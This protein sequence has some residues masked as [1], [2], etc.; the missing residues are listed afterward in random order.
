M[1]KRF[2]GR[3]MIGKDK[4]FIAI[5]IST[6][7]L[8]FSFVFWL[9]F[10]GYFQCRDTCESLSLT[11]D[12]WHPV[13]IAR[14]VQALYTLFDS[15]S[16]YLF[17]MNI[18]C[19]YAG[20]L[21]FVLPLY[22]KTRNPISYA[23]FF[24][25]VIGNIFFQNFVQHNSFG[26]PMLMW[27]GCSMLF[28][29]LLVPIAN[30]RLRIAVKICTGIVLLF[31]FLWR[32]NA[33]ISVYPLF[34]LFIYLHLKRKS[35][36]RTWAYIARFVTF[37]VAVAMIMVLILKGYPHVLSRNI[38]EAPANH[39]SLHQIAG[40]VTPANDESFIPSEWYEE[41]KGF[42]DLVTMYEKYPTAADPFNGGWD[43]T[44]ESRFF[45]RGEIEGSKALWL[46]GIVTYPANYFGH[47][48]QFIRTMWFQYPY[49]IFDSD[50]IQRAP[51][52]QKQKDLAQSYPEYERHITFSPMQ[53]SIYD[54]LFARRIVL[55]H[56]VGIILGFA[57]LAMSGVIWLSLPLRRDEML[58]FTFSTSLSACMTAIVVYLFSCSHITIHGSRARLVFNKLDRIYDMDMA[59]FEQVFSVWKRECP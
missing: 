2:R 11:T 42:D 24:L 3:E 30:K 1:P 35:I 25:T 50:K 39:I 58:L 13:F 49:W 38:C 32:H 16:F 23:L 28:F 41:G 8:L 44:D 6:A 18:F 53:K 51:M 57:V 52:S 21:L 56:I 10:P 47:I 40:M 46:K 29:Q 9:G 45:V 12:H 19:F 33:V 31:S 5:S 20:L 14:T 55:N 15:H 17:A 27:L 37:M 48:S 36:D 59:C 54:F 4:W 34:I 22:L 26:F 7:V 43:P